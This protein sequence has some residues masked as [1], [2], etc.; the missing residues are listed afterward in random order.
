QGVLSLYL[1]RPLRASDYA[2]AKLA[3][4][5]VAMLALTLGP[6]LM[7]FVGKIFLSTAPWTAFK[8]EYSKLL[9]IVG[10]SVLTSLFIA[11]IGL[12]L[13]SLAARRGYASAAVI[14]FF[15]LTPAAANIVRS[16][17]TGDLRRY[18]LLVNPVWLIS[19]FANW[20]FDV[21]AGRRTA[22]A[23]A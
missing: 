11:S 15:L 23:R 17:T 3:A 16:V 2:L 8:G 5:T 14:V 9:P 19:G 6:Q 12:A 20:L 7:M 22:I 18:A 21:E 1:S 4:L 13:S 10:G